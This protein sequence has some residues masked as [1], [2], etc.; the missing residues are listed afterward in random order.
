MI[1]LA[2]AVDSSD[3]DRSSK[4]KA[5][6]MI[7]E[8]VKNTKTKSR[9]SEYLSDLRRYSVYCCTVVHTVVDRDP[10]MHTANER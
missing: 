2:D 6:A 5:C 4:R 8:M 9:A 3:V 1:S 7:D 10:D